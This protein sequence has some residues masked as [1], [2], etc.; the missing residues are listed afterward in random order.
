MVQTGYVWMRDMTHTFNVEIGKKQNDKQ[1]GKIE[2][3]LSVKHDGNLSCS[4]KNSSNVEN[5]E[6][7]NIQLSVKHGGKNYQV[8][9]SNVEV[10]VPSITVQASKLECVQCGSGS[11]SGSA[12]NHNPSIQVGMWNYWYH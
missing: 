1:S 9:T 4:K 12:I 6:S 8:Q 5:Q 11:G 10:E 7:G 2:K 3:S